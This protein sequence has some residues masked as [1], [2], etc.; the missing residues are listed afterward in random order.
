MFGPIVVD[1]VDFVVVDFVVDIFVVLLVVLVVV[2]EVIRVVVKV[3]VVVVVVVLEV[4]VP[5]N[6]FDRKLAQLHLIKPSSDSKG[7]NTNPKSCL[8]GT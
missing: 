1:V 6:V 2:L 4:F 3:L 5:E 8:T 7:P